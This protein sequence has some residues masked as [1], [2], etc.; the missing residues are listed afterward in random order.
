MAIIFKDKDVQILIKKAVVSQRLKEGFTDDN[1]TIK[2]TQKLTDW[3]TRKQ[4]TTALLI[5]VQ[6]NKFWT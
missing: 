4:A 2:E 3:S 1:K 5:L 6:I